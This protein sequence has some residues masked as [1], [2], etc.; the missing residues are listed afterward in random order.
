MGAGRNHS[1]L[2]CGHL[3]S[4]VSWKLNLNGSFKMVDTIRSCQFS[5]SIAGK[6]L[7]AAGSAGR[8]ALGAPRAERS[9]SASASGLFPMERTAESPE[10]MNMSRGMGTWGQK[11]MSV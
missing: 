4:D 11:E 10:E 5:E 6:G 1:V 8:E 2:R 9:G 3:R 7:R